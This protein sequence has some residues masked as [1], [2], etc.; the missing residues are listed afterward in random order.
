MAVEIKIILLGF[1]AVSWEGAR[2]NQTG[3]ALWSVLSASIT[4]G[5]LCSPPKG[6]AVVLV[7]KCTV[8]DKHAH[9]SLIYEECLCGPKLWMHQIFH[10]IV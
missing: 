3:C 7:S 10:F 5:L 8:G 6:F 9:F 1:D 4:A 2:G